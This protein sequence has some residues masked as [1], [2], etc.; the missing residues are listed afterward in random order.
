[1]TLRGWTQLS[2]NLKRMSINTYLSIWEKF[3]ERYGALCVFVL[4]AH[5]EN[6]C[7]ILCSIHLTMILL[8]CLTHRTRDDS[9]ALCRLSAFITS[10]YSWQMILIKSKCFCKM[11]ICTLMLWDLAMVQIFAQPKMC[12]GE[13]EFHFVW[14]Y[15]FCCCHKQ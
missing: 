15:C 9:T 12:D 1:M 11:Y 6:A 10:I 7:Q 3:Y 2:E 4:I 5:P 14:K 8:T 13:K